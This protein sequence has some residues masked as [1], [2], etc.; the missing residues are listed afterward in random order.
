MVLVDVAPRY[1]EPG[2]PTPYFEHAI[3]YAPSIDLYLD[4]TSYLYPF[5]AL[6]TPLAD[7][8]ALDVEKGRI[9]KIPLVTAADVKLMAET[10]VDYSG[11]GSAKAHTVM[12]GEKVG[13]AIQRSAAE[14]AQQREAGEALGSRLQ[15][16]GLDGS[17]DYRFSD[18]RDLAKPLTI[19]ADYRF[20]LEQSLDNLAEGIRLIA[21][22]D[23]SAWLTWHLFE[24]RFG[25][26][27][28]CS[29]LDLTDVVTAV[30]PE[31]YAAAQ[32]PPPRDYEETVKGRTALGEV[33]G[34]VAY[35]IRFEAAGREVKQTTHAIFG[36]S[37]ALC[38]AR[39]T[40]RAWRA[41]LDLT[42][43]VGRPSRSLPRMCRECSCGCGRFWSR[44]ISACSE[45]VFGG[46]RP[47]RGAGPSLNAGLRDRSPATAE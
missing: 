28:A 1:R 44:R 19:S 5:G 27:A 32:L 30:L 7:K 40:E 14:A 16:F 38:D 26:A 3:L 42:N 25:V 15:T 29:P 2:L 37:S 24:D 22:V 46:A 12:T 31:G 10:R 23:S 11:D 34:T 21:P 47:C 39:V 35:H 4:A 43:T 41:A 18:P 13:D 6:P 20:K 9:V 8:P 36:F 17:G 45:A 33:T